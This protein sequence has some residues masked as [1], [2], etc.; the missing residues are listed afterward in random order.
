MADYLRATRS[1]YYGVVG[2]LPLLLAYELLLMLDGRGPAGQIRN[3]GDVWLRMLLAS[4]DVR[5]AHA[6]AVMIFL[7]LLAI[8]LFRRDA[9]PLRARYVLGLLGESFLYSLVLGLLINI[10]L[11]FI[12]TAIPSAILSR[13]PFALSIPSMVAAHGPLAAAGTLGG[14]LTPTFEQGL[15]LALGAGL[16]EEFIFRVLLLGGLLGVLRLILPYSIAAVAAIVLASLLFAAAHYV[17]PLADPY[18]FLSFLFRFIAGLL[19]TGL[20]HARGFAVTAYAHAF[21]DIRVILF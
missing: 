20:Y 6:T 21:Y 3:A 5:P 14:G 16:F 8:P 18:S 1:G 19:F 10:I 13:T 9:E 2:A 11:Q 4:L 15:A 12:F 7:L 17:G